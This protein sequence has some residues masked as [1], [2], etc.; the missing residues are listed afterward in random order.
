MFLSAVYNS[1]KFFEISLKSLFFLVENDSLKDS[2]TYITKF[3]NI[4]TPLKGPPH[5]DYTPMPLWE[6]EFPRGS[7]E[8]LMRNK[9]K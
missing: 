9:A 1:I 8:A 4:A 2:I 6:F 7:I 5:M 3:H